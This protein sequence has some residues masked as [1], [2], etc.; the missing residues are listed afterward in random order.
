MT[1][2]RQDVIE[3]VRQWP[4]DRQDQAADLLLEL[5][6]QQ[7]SRYRLTP[8]QVREVERIQKQVRSG[9][10]KFATDEE[11]AEFWRKCGL[12]D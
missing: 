12:E 5:E 10:A 9:T 2:R 6:A 11:M 4:D 7:T 1:Q 8:E 3:R